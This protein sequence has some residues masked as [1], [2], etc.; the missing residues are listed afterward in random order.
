MVDHQGNVVDGDE[1]L[2][3]IACERRRRNINSVV[4]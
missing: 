3:V 2:F 4:L 1:M